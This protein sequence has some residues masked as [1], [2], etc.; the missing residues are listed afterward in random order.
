M[1]SPLAPVLANIFMAHYEKKWIETFSGKKP[2]LY[3]RYVDDIFAVFS[4]EN[5]A[6]LFF[7]Y[8]NKQHPNISFTI[9]KQINGKLAFLDV[10]V[11]N[12]SDIK[13]SIFRKKTFTGLLTNFFSFTSMSYQI[14]LINCLI[15]R[16]FKIN[17]TWSGFHIDLQTVKNYFKEE[18]VPRE[19]NS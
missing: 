11:H 9:E 15:D 13:T 17:N 18:H 4:N 3:K 14:G 2:I 10:L 5:K 12:F 16:A 7:E 1:G 8:I 19:F 6:D